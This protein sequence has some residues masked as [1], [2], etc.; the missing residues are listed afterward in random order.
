MKKHVKNRYSHLLL[1]IYTHGLGSQKDL[2]TRIPNEFTKR[3]FYVACR[4]FFMF[5]RETWML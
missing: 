3:G 2:D 1:I 5:S 4:N